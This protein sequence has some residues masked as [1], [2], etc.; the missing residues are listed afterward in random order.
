MVRTLTSSIFAG[1]TTLSFFSTSNVRTPRRPRSDASAS[2]IGPPPTISTGIS[3]MAASWKLAWA[4][5]ACS[6]NGSGALSGRSA[7]N[8]L[9]V[10]EI[11]V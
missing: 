5:Q 6:G 2:P 3:I 10:I 7:R 9:S 11:S 1:P 4:D 8:T